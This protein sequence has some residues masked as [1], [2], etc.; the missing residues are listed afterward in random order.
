MSAA[1]REPFGRVDG[2]TGECGRE[3]I[4][5]NVEVDEPW[6]A[7]KEAIVT[8]RSLT[9]R[10]RLTLIYLID[11][12][13]R[14]GWEIRLYGH[15]LPTLGFTRNQ[16]PAIRDSLR[17]AGYYTQQKV[18]RE[19]GT[20]WWR[21]T[22]TSHPATPPQKPALAEPALENGGL[23]TALSYTALSYTKK[24][25]HHARGRAWPRRRMRRVLLLRVKESSGGRGGGAESLAG[26]KPTWFGQKS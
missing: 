13:R 17:T 3:E 9:P 1:A 20:T 21:R 10:A 25:K 7:V 19:D 23:Y 24:Q 4:N 26:V 11:L 6:M 14:P 16:W 15:V 18:R 5:L 22:V 8:D 12:A 2:Q